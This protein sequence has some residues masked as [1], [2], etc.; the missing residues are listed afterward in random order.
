MSKITPWL[1]FENEAEEAA[2]YYT[3]IFKNSRIVEIRRYG[4][5]APLPAGTVMTVS[6]ELEGV[7]FVALNGGMPI[8][9]TEA[10]SFFVDCAD[11]AEVDYYWDRLTEN[12]GEPGQCGW[13]KDR[14]GQSWQI[15]PKQLGELLG[16]PD[17]ERAR[18]A[19]T[20]MLGMS[21]I[22]VAALRAAADG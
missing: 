12:G 2:T 18:R 16:D 21:K 8:A 20:A 1:W 3:S 7:V 19:M 4:E 17:P 14:Y 9:H 5:G 6:F 11:Q 10:N 13:L 15:V 22:D